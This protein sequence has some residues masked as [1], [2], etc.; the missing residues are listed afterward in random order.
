MTSPGLGNQ[1]ILLEK[2]ITVTYDGLTLDSHPFL[3]SGDPRL[4]S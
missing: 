3:S 4:R 1:K 2:G